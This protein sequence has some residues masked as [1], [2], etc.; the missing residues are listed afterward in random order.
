M[1]LFVKC[2]LSLS[3]ILIEVRSCHSAECFRFSF[4]STPNL[5][6]RCISVTFHHEDQQEWKVSK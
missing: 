1:L 4:I 2:L 5:A 6:K 3:D